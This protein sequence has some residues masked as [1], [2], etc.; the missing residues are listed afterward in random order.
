[1]SKQPVV[2]KKAPNITQEIIKTKEL[3]YYMQV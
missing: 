3:S 2:K 1:M